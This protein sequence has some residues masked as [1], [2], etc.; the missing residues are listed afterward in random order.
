MT[1]SAPV[2]PERIMQFAW[3]YV[4]PLVLEAAVRHRVFDVLD[5]GPKTL[6]Q[7]QKETGASERGLAAVMHALVGM[8]FLAKD[9]QGQFSLTPES[10][11]FLVST[12][13]SF[14]GGLLR[15]GSE[16]L[17][18]KWL[19]LN[20]IVETGR[21][22]TSVNLEEA[23]GDFF[24][25][26]VVDIFPLSYPAAQTLSRHLSA[27]TVVRV[28]DL[29]AG[30]GVWSIALAQGSE[31]ATVTV[32]DWPEVIPATRKTV[33]KFGLAERYSFI[34]GDLLQVDFGSGHTVATLGH[35][36]HSEGRDR[37]QELLKKTFQALAPGGTIA[38]AE[39]LVNADR[40]GP[41]NGLFFAVNML[42][43]TDTGDTYSFEEISSWLG[44][45]GFI[46]PRTLDAPGPSPLILATKP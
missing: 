20:K 29:A 33:G 28:L 37:S 8:N 24:Q 40:T 26:F 2:T 5:G 3:G 16:Q 17:I 4:P 44:E 10:S 21:P 1:T 7:V 36:L 13:P 32:V 31:K 22:A 34:P 35:I 18:P 15:H 25:Q 19:H 45:A 12:K 43:N 9:M 30:S 23:G 41:L 46:N 11:T 42:V 14:Q 38:I 39:F 27:D 6:A